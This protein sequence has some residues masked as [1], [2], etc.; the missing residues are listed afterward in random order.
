MKWIASNSTNERPL[1]K[2]ELV[3]LFILIFLIEAVFKWFRYYV[4]VDFRISAYVKI[5]MEF[6]FLVYI[7]KNKPRK[8]IFLVGLT[9]IFLI[10]QLIINPI[11]GILD[12]IEILTKYYFILLLLIYTN[13]LSRNKPYNNQLLYVFEWIIII[14]SICILIAPFIELR[15]FKTYSGQRFGYSGFLIK[16]GAATYIYCVALYY[17]VHQVFV[18][19][20]ERKIFP[21]VL[22]FIASLLLGTKAIVL[23][24]ALLVLYIYFKR[25]LYKNWYINGFL[26]LFFLSVIAFGKTIFSR[27]LQFSPSLERIYKEESFWTMVT[28]YRNVLFTEEFLPILAQ[29]WNFVN[30]LFGGSVDMHFRSQ[31]EFFDAFYFFGI[32]GTILYLFVFFKEFVSFKLNSNTTFFIFSIL[33]IAAI[34]GNFFYN[35]VVAIYMVIIKCYFENS[36]REDNPNIIVIN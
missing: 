21:L 8:L 9:A 15:L 23:Y 35:A 33:C 12:N 24:I 17:Y 2:N 18:V 10:G 20:V 26:V 25:T 30:Y 36:E 19:G 11:A 13:L 1:W 6:F 31:F 32:V 27:L 28:S 7:L 5:L 34:S 14:N 29:K 16:S 3:I 22:V 4:V